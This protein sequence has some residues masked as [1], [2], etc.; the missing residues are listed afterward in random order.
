MIERSLH[1]VR[2]RPA[3]DDYSFNK[4]IYI[5]RDSI[6]IMLLNPLNAHSSKYE[7]KKSVANTNVT[8]VDASELAQHRRDAVMLDLTKKSNFPPKR[9]RIAKFDEG[10]L[11]RL[12]LYESERVHHKP[13][14]DERKS[15][16]LC[17]IDRTIK[18]ATKT[19]CT[20]CAV[21]LCT[22]FLLNETETCFEKWHTSISLA[23][24]HNEQC[25][26]LRTQRLA[27]EGDSKYDH[28]RSVRRRLMQD[29]YNGDDADV[30]A[31][32]AMIEEEIRRLENE[33]DADEAEIRRLQDEADAEGD[34]NEE[35]EG[36]NGEE[37]AV[38]D[39]VTG[40]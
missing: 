32:D 15:C 7:K 20:V 3:H 10:D 36:D 30:E 34:N 38:Y 37:M 12:R 9:Y 29:E 1:S 14:V 40:C 18:R 24:V 35:E 33:A 31:E 5:K 27:L 23:T 17:Q 26:A 4:S 19:V 22:R 16:V 13:K 6:G 39:G 25:A 21:P 8:N 2:Q 11:S 28:A